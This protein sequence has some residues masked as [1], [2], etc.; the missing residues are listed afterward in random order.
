MFLLIKNADV[1]SPAHLGMKDVFIANGRIAFIEDELELCLPGM[2]TIDLEGRVLAPG[3]IDQHVHITGGGGES[4]FASRAPEANIESIVSAGVTSVVGLLGTDGISRSVEN[5][6]A[7]AKAL[8]EEGISA[9]CLTGNYAVPTLTLTGSVSRD[10][11]F[12]DEIIGVKVAISDHRSSAPTKEELARLATEARVAGMLGKKTGE[13]HMHT[14]R[15]RSGL[16]DIIDIV[17]TTDIPISQFRPTHVGNQPDDAVT[18]ANMSGFIDFTCGNVE[19]TAALMADI[20]SRVPLHSVTLSSDANGSMPMWNEKNELIGITIATE[21][22]LLQTV[23]ALV[24]AGMPLETA[25]LCVTENPAKALQFYPRKG[26]VA[27]GADADLIVLRPDVTLDGVIAGGEIM[28]QDGVLQK[29][30]FFRS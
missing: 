12:I 16:A 30:G 4:G 21:K 13:V 26:T 29:H 8:R 22:S 27:A 18:F 9:W 17:N 23:G 24:R 2:R 7:K 20:W 28:M 25:L 5:L 3:L 15:G 19:K 10:I 1:Y 6:V 11:A 14:G